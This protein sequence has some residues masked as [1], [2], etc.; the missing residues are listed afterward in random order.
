MDINKN[1]A[2]RAGC[3]SGRHGWFPSTSRGPAIDSMLAFVRHGSKHSTTPPSAC[4]CACVCAWGSTRRTDQ[5]GVKPMPSE[6]RAVS[7]EGRPRSN[8]PATSS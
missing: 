7:S 3:A 1:T 2:T 5:R 8:L 6:V 4:V